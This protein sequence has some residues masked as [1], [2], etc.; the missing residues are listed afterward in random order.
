MR[1]E[2]LDRMRPIYCEF[3]KQT[4]LAING[5]RCELCGKNGGLTE[6]PALEPAKPQDS[7]WAPPDAVP[8]ASVSIM[9]SC[10]FLGLGC[11]AGIA[12]ATSLPS[13]GS[14]WLGA[15]IMRVTLGGISGMIGGA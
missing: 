5:D 11:V 7:R 13:D 2:F 4:Y 6:A 1:W 9:S 3:C 15:L 12:I 8:D 14:H 10:L